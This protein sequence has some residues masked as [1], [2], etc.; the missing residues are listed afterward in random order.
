MI[1]TA[2]ISAGKMP[3]RKRSVIEMPP[4]AAAENR[5]MLCEGG[6]SSATSAAEIVTF[7]AKS[8]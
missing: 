7:T 4:P 2:S 3:A 6:T 1:A 8:R 5:I